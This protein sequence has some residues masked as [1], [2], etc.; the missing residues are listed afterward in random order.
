MMTQ[1]QK[2][3]FQY[4]Q[5]RTIIGT[6][7]GYSIFYLVRKN[8]SFA[9]PGLTAEY[10]ITKATF[11]AILAIAS[12]MYGVSKLING[13]L[14]DRLNGRWHLVTGLSVSA[15]VNILFGAGAM[16]CAYF[17]GA[18]YGPKFV[19]YLV[20][21]FAVLYVV[22]N[23]FQGCGFPPCNRPTGYHL[24]SSLPRCP[25]GTPRILSELSSSPCFAA[26]SWG[27]PEWT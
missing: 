7:I 5:W 19:N 9:I 12:F 8:F 25:S 14:A 16:I 22:N 2:K 1:E 20:I 24:T 23:V 17:V 27:T 15:F 21:L 13:F 10:G 6:M 18:D 26:T 11:G 3:R 4:W